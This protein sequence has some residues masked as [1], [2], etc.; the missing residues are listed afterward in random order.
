MYACFRLG[1]AL[2]LMTLGG[3]G[4]YSVVVA[5]PLVQAEFGVARAD[6]SLPY[7][8]TMVG[9]GLGGILMG[10]LADRCGVMVPALI[11]SAALGV[12]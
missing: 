1:I 12:G 4:M 10:R 9:F 5:L 6:A 11:G 3:S 7:T 2:L 8:L